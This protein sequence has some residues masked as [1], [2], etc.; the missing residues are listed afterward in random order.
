MAK[1]KKS[2]R[3]QARGKKRDQTGDRAQAQMR[4]PASLR[5]RATSRAQA[6]RKTIHKAAPV[7][8]SANGKRSNLR[9]A[10]PLPENLKNF[11]PRRIGIMYR[12]QT[13]DAIDQA[14]ELSSWLQ[15]HGYKV[16][17]APGQQLGRGCVKL[18]KQNLDEIDWMIVLG[19]D[20]TYLRAVELLEGR[21]IPIL[22]VNMGSLGFLTE[23]RVEELYKTVLYTLD[24][25]MEFRPRSML[26]ITV[27]R[28]NK[29]RQS[30][31][32]L[33][34][35]VIERGSSTH[36]ISLAVYNE[37]H[38]V[39][40]IK[41]DALIVASPTGSTAYNLAAGG[42]ILHPDVRAIV[43]TPV[44]PHA[45]TTRPMIFPD[46][47]E[48]IFKLLTTDKTAVLTI[49]GRYCGEITTDDEVTITRHAFEHFVIRRT[50]HNYFTLLREKLKFGERD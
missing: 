14:K 20:G 11:S 26:K 27:S 46:D 30:F 12:P 19:G 33:N 32:A 40:E 9:M 7:L 39:G 21:Q 8:A 13:P 41:A 18:S 44:C 23:T 38:L 1:T 25:K 45:L 5:E 6:R 17:S 22:G 15:E 24:K 42:P 36:L 10:I 49:D 47:Q 43:L 3:D 31:I 35:A 4:E 37:C 48:I 2:V 28:K 34:D 50:S 29:M 16:Y